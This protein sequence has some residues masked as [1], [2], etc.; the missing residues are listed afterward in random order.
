M[1]ISLWRFLTVYIFI[2]GLSACAQ[3]RPLQEAS[4]KSLSLDEVNAICSTQAATVEKVEYI[5]VPAELETIVEATRDTGHWGSELV[6][7]PAEYNID[8]S[9]KTPA[10][11]VILRDIHPFPVEHYERQIVKTPSYELKRTTMHDGR[12]LEEPISDLCSRYMAG[13]LEIQTE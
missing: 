3:T 7:L 13:T 5:T 9:V 12:I 11:V 2:L 4:H 1:I 8:G 10:R 6:K